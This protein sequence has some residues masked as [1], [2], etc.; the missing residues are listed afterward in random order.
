VID[1]LSVTLLTYVIPTCGAAIISGAFTIYN[2]HKTKKVTE[3]AD[4][5]AKMTAQASVNDTFTRAFEAADKHWASYV[6]A[7]ERR[8]DDQEKRN[9]ELADEINKTGK[10]IDDAEMR[11]EAE[12]VARTKAEHLYS[13]AII[14]LRRVIRWVNANMPGGD[15]PSPPPEIDVDLDINA[16]VWG[17]PTPR[18][19]HPHQGGQE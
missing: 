10:R 9:D 5:A 18:P 15:Y 12:R 14:Y 16:A 11:A 6:A 4:E 1:P 17:N 7:M 2:T 19:L 3:S 13:V 8:V